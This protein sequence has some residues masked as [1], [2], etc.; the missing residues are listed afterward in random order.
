VVVVG[1]IGIEGLVCALL[2]EEGCVAA[3]VADAGAEVVEDG[4]GGC[5]AGSAPFCF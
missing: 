4:V 2:A 5:L 1:L 3:V